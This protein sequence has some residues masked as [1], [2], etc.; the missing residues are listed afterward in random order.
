MYKKGVDL[1]TAT[2]IFAV[3]FIA[4]LLIVFYV[5]QGIAGSEA[6][7]KIKIASET[8]HKNHMLTDLL[9]Y[10]VD[11]GKT[12]GDAIAENQLVLACANTKRL[13]KSLYGD[14]FRFVLSFD[15]SDFCE[16]AEEPY[17]SITLRTM[18]PT[19]NK[20]VKEVKLEV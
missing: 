13:F 7:S 3:V 17:D 18:I 10:P 2:F 15:D 14:D 4:I 8:I 20:E 12:I 6:E 5:W 9:N 1:R 11:N 16:T 19:D